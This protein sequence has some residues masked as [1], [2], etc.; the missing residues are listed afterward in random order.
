MY[1]S[2]TRIVDGYRPP[3]PATWRA[4]AVA[5]A[6]NTTRTNQSSLQFQV[7]TA[8]GDTVTLS[9]QAQQMSNL[10]RASYR[11]PG[12][13]GSGA[14]KVYE[15]SQSNTLNASVTVQGSLSDE[16]LQDIAKVLT[17]LSQGKAVTDAGTVAAA[18][19]SYTNQ[20]SVDRVRV[21]VQG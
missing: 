19:Y 17:A 5:K 13:G 12:Q 15:S 6:S 2:S 7:R 16:E 14:A 4:P 21:S 3:T 9:I 1:L 11:T 10:S 8:E 20:T 18:S